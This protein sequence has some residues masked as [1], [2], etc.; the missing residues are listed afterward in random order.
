MSKIVSKKRSTKTKPSDEGFGLWQR[1]VIESPYRGET[2]EQLEEHKRYLL[3]CIRDCIERLESP[4]ASHRMLTDSLDD[5]DPLERKLGIFAGTAYWP[6]AHVI[7]FYCDY[8]VSTGMRMAADK[9]IP[10][11]GSPWPGAHDFLDHDRPWRPVIEIRKL[12]PQIKSVRE[13]QETV[14]LIDRFNAGGIPFERPGKSA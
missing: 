8:G 14:D 11:W 12:F 2:P 10:R 6:F 1:T 9:I 13:E 5:D 7:A 3:R 4:Y